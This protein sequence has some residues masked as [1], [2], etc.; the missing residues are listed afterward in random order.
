MRQEQKWFLLF[1]VKDLFPVFQ[2]Q[3]EKRE[4]EPLAVRFFKQVRIVQQELIIIG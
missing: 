1:V 3:R 4:G 2:D